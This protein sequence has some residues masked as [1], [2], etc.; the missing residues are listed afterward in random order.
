ME[1]ASRLGA[2]AYVAWVFV[3]FVVFETVQLMRCW[4]RFVLDAMEYGG[5]LADGLGSVLVCVVEVGRWSF[6]HF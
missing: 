1:Y 4:V 2:Y 3:F 6:L 5:V